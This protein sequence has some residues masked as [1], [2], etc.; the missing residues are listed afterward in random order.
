MII[1]N[2]TESYAS[3]VV[4]R[5]DTSQPQ[6]SFFSDWKAKQL[7]L[8]FSSQH[9]LQS[10]DNHFVTVPSSQESQISPMSNRDEESLSTVYSPSS[11]TSYKRGNIRDSIYRALR[12]KALLGIGENGDQELE[13]RGLLPLSD[14]PRTIIV[15]GDEQKEQEVEA[16][17]EERNS[18]QS[19]QE[20]QRQAMETSLAEGLRVPSHKRAL[21]LFA[22]W[23][24]GGSPSQSGRMSSI[25]SRGMKS[26]GGSLRWG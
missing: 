4:E 21:S 12:I 26:P 1:M 15:V 11:S 22:H 13:R 17:P 7:P 2:I 10:N 6:S 8:S 9:E 20:L 14:S 25:H 18:I 24:G 3:P 5:K 19:S 23:R 16:P